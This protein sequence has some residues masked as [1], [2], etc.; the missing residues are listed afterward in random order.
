MTF[1][2]YDCVGDQCAKETQIQAVSGNERAPETSIPKK[3]SIASII[4]FVVAL[5][6]VLLAFVLKEQLF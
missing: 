2:L 3:D 5:M 1:K 4:S 6:I